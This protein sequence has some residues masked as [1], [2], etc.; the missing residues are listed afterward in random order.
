MSQL[1]PAMERH[2]HLSLNPALREQLMKVSASSIDRWLKDE[3]QL[4]STE[5]LL[6][7]EDTHPGKFTEGHRRT[8]QR[9]VAGM[10]GQGGLRTG[11]RNSC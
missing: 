8:L 3:P 6:K 11:L 10:A 2:G 1:I 4:G 9:S 5:L 7:L